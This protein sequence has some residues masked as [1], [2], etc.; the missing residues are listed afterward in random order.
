[1]YEK[2]F[3]W[4]VIGASRVRESRSVCGMGEIS[5]AVIFEPAKRLH[6]SQSDLVRIKAHLDATTDIQPKPTSF[7]E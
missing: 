2:R 6:L 5:E 1:M 4:S 3:K 7:A